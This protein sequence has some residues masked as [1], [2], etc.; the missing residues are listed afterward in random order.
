MELATPGG[1]VVCIGLKDGEN[2]SDSRDIIT[3]ELTVHGSY[4][5]TSDDFARATELLASRQVEPELLITE[6][7]LDE[8]PNAFAELTENPGTNLAKVVLRP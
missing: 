5:Y 1:H 4:A 6:M 8:G 7:P 2:Y 3:K